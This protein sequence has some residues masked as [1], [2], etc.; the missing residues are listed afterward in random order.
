[1][2][3]GTYVTLPALLAALLLIACGGST[4]V[5]DLEPRDINGNKIERGLPDLPETMPPGMAKIK[6]RTLRSA[7]EGGTLFCILEI[8]EVEAVSASAPPLKTGKI[9]EVQMPRIVWMRFDPESR[10]AP[11]VS[12]LLRASIQ[13]AGKPADSLASTAWHLK[14][15]FR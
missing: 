11:A 5:V 9:I 3:T 2:K 13:Y 1:M 14:R 4:P 10:P 15:L 6:G 7:E 12:D 8:T